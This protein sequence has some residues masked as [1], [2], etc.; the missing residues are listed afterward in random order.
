MT[1]TDATCPWLERDGYFRRV[2]GIDQAAELL[3]DPRLHSDLVGLFEALGVTSGPLWETMSAS[4]LSI[5]GEQHKRSRAHVAGRFTPRAVETARPASSAAAARLAQAFAQ[6]GGGEF[7]ADFAVPYI[8]VGTCGVIGFPPEEFADITRAIDLVS[9]AT[10]DL[11]SRLDAC[12]DG[13]E[14]LLDHAR[15]ALALRRAEPADDVLTLLVELIDDGSLSDDV[16]V[17]LVV[18]LLSAG[19]EPSVNQLGLMILVL[20]ERP[21]V[22]DAI[23]SGALP[24]A[25]AVEELLRLRSTNRGVMRRVADT[26]DL[27]GQRFPTGEQ[28]VIGLAAANHDRGRFPNPDGFDPDAN[29][30]PH[31]AFGFGPHY[32][33][34]AALA[35]LQLQEAITA[36]TAAMACPVVD[37]VLI[38]DGAGLI[39]PETLHLTVRAR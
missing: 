15:R 19:H 36:L 3:A 8:A 28:V 26:I 39:G 16:A 12:A 35:R 2:T 38:E 29:A 9:H 14:Q 30:R 32:C 34:G 4:F 21:E 6:R 23:A 31:L 24:V 18:G 37:E 13:V 25:R 27:D 5:N 17:S 11:A 1:E 22:W 7:V 20:A 33:L 10:K